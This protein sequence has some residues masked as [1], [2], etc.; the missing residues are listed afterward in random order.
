LA[1]EPGEPP[2]HILRPRV[3]DLGTTWP[4][5]AHRCRHE[6]RDELAWATP[7]LDPEQP[8]A[9]LCRR[10]QACQLIVWH[11]HLPTYEQVSFSCERLAHGTQPS[12]RR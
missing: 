5:H 9:V 8:L 11:N 6:L 10:E 4:A 7:L 3:E 12:E 2:S 1:V